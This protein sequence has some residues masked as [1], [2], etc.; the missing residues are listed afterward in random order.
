MIIKLVRHGQSQ[1]NIGEVMSHDVGDHR[2]HLTPTGVAQARQVGKTIGSEFLHNCLFYRS[3]Y[4]R[5]R[6]TSFALLQGAGIDY[7]NF[8]VLEDP[9]LREAERGYVDAQ[10]QHALRE[11]HGWFYYR[12]AGG[13]SPADVYDRSSAFMESAL[14]EVNRS[15]QENILIV[16]HGM[17]IRCLV[18]RFMHLSVEQFE[19]M[20]NPK[21]CAVITI[22]PKAQAQGEIVFSNEKWAV[23]GEISLY[24]S[25]P[26]EFEILDSIASYRIP[27]DS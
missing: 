3:P 26:D 10:S 16:T 25:D 6:E 5:T 9:R 13:E 20:K 18:S 27:E 7:K 22:S 4:M 19:Q 23:T 24:K 17:T 21:N 12:H 2:I 1:S 11:I 8:S 15:N 14:R